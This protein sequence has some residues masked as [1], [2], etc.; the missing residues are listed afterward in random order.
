M[1]QPAPETSPGVCPQRRARCLVQLETTRLG[2]R[3]KELRR[4]HGPTTN[5]LLDTEPPARPGSLTPGT[6]GH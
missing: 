3:R 4:Q 2:H 1:E 5:C 6:R